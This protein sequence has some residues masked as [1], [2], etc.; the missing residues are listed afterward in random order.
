MSETFEELSSAEQFARLNMVA[1]DIYKIEKQM[2]NQAKILDIS[3]SRYQ[4]G[5]EVY[6]VKFEKT[7]DPSGVHYY[8]V[9]DGRL[10]RDEKPFQ[11]IKPDRYKPISADNG[12]QLIADLKKAQEAFDANKITFSELQ[13]SQQE[14]RALAMQMGIPL[15]TLLQQSDVIVS[16]E[17]NSSVPST[18]D[19][20]AN[21]LEQAS[22]LLGVND[23]NGS[24]IK[25]DGNGNLGLNVS[26]IDNSPI[27]SEQID[28][29]KKVTLH[30]TFNDF[31]GCKYESYRMIKAS[32][33]QSLLIGVTADGVAEIISRTNVKFDQTTCKTLP[34]M[35]ENNNI[36]EVG[37][38]ASFDISPRTESGPRRT[39]GIYN[40][41]GKIGAFCGRNDHGKMIAET[42]PSAVYNPKRIHNQAILDRTNRDT[43]PEAQSAARR[44]DDNKISNT[45]TLGDGQNL[46]PM[47]Y[48]DSKELLDRYSQQLG[49]NR[50]TLESRYNARLSD[51]PNKLTDEEIISQEAK[52]MYQSKTQNGQYNHSYPEDRSYDNALPPRSPSGFT[53]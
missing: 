27:S 44:V 22:K 21:K 25:Q 38:V 3:H 30:E 20:E 46:T 40:N 37:L 42:I 18:T 11:N 50:D 6:K 47:S 49:I 1:A 16:I 4:N 53:N 39:I 29:N 2:G 15:E 51:N 52:L 14:I 12:D 28:G 19:K 8:V 41:N 34:L 24:A 23:A 13:R 35:Q 9:Q 10:V 7:D 32:S 5:Q 33:G 31:I 26:A 43:S 36:V 45:H 17:G 48:E